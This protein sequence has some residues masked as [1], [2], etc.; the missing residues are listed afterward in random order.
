MT[1]YGISYLKGQ[2]GISQIITVVVI[3]VAVVALAVFLVLY[4]RHRKSKFRD[5]AIIALLLVILG[6]GYGYV[7][8]QQNRTQSAK[9]T[10]MVNFVEAV[11]HEKQVPV[12]DVLVNSRYLNDDVIVKIG[13]DYYTVTLNTDYTAFTL[14][15]THMLADVTV[16]R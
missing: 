13:K 11:A 1:F 16:E 3:V 15:R 2:R 7:H 9:A 5:L 14:E 8:Y 4:V 10:Q 6:A 12:A